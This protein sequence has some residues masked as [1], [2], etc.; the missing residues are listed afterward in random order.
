MNL[1]DDI[2]R[3]YIY[4]AAT[5]MEE[6]VGD[7]LPAEIKWQKQYLLEL[8]TREKNTQ[9]VSNCLVKAFNKLDIHPSLEKVTNRKSMFY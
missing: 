9:A 7:L 6:Q 3:N 2:I 4:N 1:Q 8:H 5:K